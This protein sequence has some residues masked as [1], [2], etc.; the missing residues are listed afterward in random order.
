M[1]AQPEPT[2]ILPPDLLIG[3]VGV[4]AS[5]KSTLIR[6][7][8]ERG[9]RCRHIAQEHSYVADMWQR[10]THPD[11]L[12]FL[13]VS[14]DVTIRRKKLNWTRAEYEEQLRRLRHAYANADIR[15][16][17]DDLNPDELLHIVQDKIHRILLKRVE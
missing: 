8:T 10:L 14:Y 13:E 6:L 2:Q 17:T 1:T 7:L 16:L 5:G 3:V 15:I 12:V 9:Y 4:C 11:I